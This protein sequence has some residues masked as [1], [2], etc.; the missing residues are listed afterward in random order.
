MPASHTCLKSNAE[1]PFMPAELMLIGF[2]SAFSNMNIYAEAKNVRA[3]TFE[4]QKVY[5][6]DVVTPEQAGPV[7]DTLYI[8]RKT[9]LPVGFVQDHDRTLYKDVVAKAKL[10]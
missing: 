5:A 8:D 4:K 10:T 3:T 1:N 9:Y 6:V 2:E 7:K